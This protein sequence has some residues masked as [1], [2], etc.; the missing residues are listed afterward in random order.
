MLPA[1][2]FNIYILRK[3][4]GMRQRP[5]PPSRVHCTM[6]FIPNHFGLDI[7]SAASGFRG[8]RPLKPLAF[9]YIIGL[10]VQT[11]QHAKPAP[12]PAEA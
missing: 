4:L 6:L 11:M 10:Y 7:Y 3:W 5:K 12:K 8:L 1:P 2:G 9:E